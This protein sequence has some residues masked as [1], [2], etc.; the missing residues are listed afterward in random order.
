MTD[1]KQYENGFIRESDD[2]RAKFDS[3]SENDWELIGGGD[4]FSAEKPENVSH[5]YVTETGIIDDTNGYC[6]DFHFDKEFLAEVEKHMHL[7]S[8]KYERD[9]WRKA[10]D[11]GR[12]FNAIIRHAVAAFLRPKDINSRHEAAIVANALML[13]N[14]KKESAKETR[15]S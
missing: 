3:Y 14:A 11:L 2:S 1:I 15:L 5:L 10:R 4:V 6:H 8:I 13:W 12:I 7:G 9:N